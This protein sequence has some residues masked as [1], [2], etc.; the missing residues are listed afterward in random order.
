MAGE[1]VNEYLVLLTHKRLLCDVSGICTNGLMS[2]VYLLTSGSGFC[3]LLGPL[4]YRR[5]PHWRSAARYRIGNCYLVVAWF[6]W[7]T[8]VL[9]QIIFTSGGSSID[10]LVF[11]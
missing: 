1:V 3:F 4:H 7:S 6:R 11:D 9:T 5:E 2:D 10:T 8:V